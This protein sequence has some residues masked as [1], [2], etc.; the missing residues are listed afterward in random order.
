MVPMTNLVLPVVERW[1][2]GKD[3]DD[4]LFPSPEGEYLRS[5]NWRRRVHW[6]TTSLGRR[7][8]DLRQTAAS[9]WIAAGVDIQTV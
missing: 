9:L 6:D 7:P 8:H 2:V 1:A 3:P 5:G 4:L